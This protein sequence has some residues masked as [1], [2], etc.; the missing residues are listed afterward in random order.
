[1]LNFLNFILLFAGQLW[2]IYL[3][4][5]F[6]VHCGTYF[7]LSFVLFLIYP[8]FDP[9]IYWLLTFLFLYLFIYLMFVLSLQ[10]S[11]CKPRQISQIQYSDGASII[12]NLS[13]SKTENA[14]RFWFIYLWVLVVQRLFLCIY[15]SICLLFSLLRQESGNIKL[16]NRS[17]SVVVILTIHEEQQKTKQGTF[18]AI[19]RLILYGEGFWG[20]RVTACWEIGR[21]TKYTNLVHSF[22]VKGHTKSQQILMVPCMFLFYR[23]SNIYLF[24]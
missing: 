14:F 1:M 18:L 2:F 24:I 8:F 13:S 3:S 19:G 7:C 20:E 15:L 22:C 10:N 4:T 21:W 6:L 16:L 9:F 17:L 12:L 23:L 5:L 11:F